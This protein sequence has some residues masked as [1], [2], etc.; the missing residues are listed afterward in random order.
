M[1]KDWE[2]NVRVKRE[3]SEKALK[4]LAL[5]LLEIYNEIEAE[6]KEGNRIEEENKVIV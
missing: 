6:K 4:D 2:F 5:T 1:K 3:P